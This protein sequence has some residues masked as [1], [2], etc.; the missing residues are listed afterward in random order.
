MEKD[1]INNPFLG[2]DL[3]SGIRKVRMAIA[4]KGKGKS[5]GARILTLNLLLDTES[6]EITLLTIYDKGEIS[7]VKDDFIKYLISNL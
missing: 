6:M 4:S 7:D 2:D 3:G 5:G 1:I